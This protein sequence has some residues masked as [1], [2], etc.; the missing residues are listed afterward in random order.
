MSRSVT[1]PHQQVM[2]DASQ[3]GTIR[4]MLVAGDDGSAHG[5]LAIATQGGAHRYRAVS[6]YTGTEPIV[7]IQLE[8]IRTD[9]GTVDLASLEIY[10][11]EHTGAA[12]GPVEAEIILNRLP[13]GVE[14]VRATVRLEVR[15]EPQHSPAAAAS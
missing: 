5:H 15:D 3:A 11:R 4:G 6:G 9:P 7:S 12:Q 8:E 14:I 13:D 2:F 10:S 1:I